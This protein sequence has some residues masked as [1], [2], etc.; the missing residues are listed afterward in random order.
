M[1]IVTKTG[2]KGETS[3]M[4][5]RR[6][7]KADPHVD[8]YGCIDELTAALG[9]ARSICSE[10]FVSEQIFAVQKEL[11]VVMGEL[12]TASQ[13]RERYLKDGLP[14][15]TLAIVDRLTA[16]VLGL[17]KDRPRYLEDRLT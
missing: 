4:Y 1:S 14:V 17:E 15:T 8:A 10:K 6:V 3:L 12:A 11:I 9:V 13:D 16:F 5:G 2:D 7:S